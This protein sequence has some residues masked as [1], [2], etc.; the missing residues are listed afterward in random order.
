M[1]VMLYEE[2]LHE[3]LGE[4]LFPSRCVELLCPRYG[5]LNDTYLI[6]FSRLIMTLS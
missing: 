4:G 3:T 6:F 2:P 5:F 1:S